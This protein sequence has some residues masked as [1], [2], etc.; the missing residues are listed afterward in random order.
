MNPINLNGGSEIEARRTPARAEA[1]R[2][3]APN[4]LPVTGNTGSLPTA[5]TISVSDGLARVGELT[6]Q[7]GQL[8]DVR[9]EYVA[10]LREQVQSGNYHPS[11]E[12]IAAAL[13]VSRV[14][15]ALKL[16]GEPPKA[17][18][19]FPIDLGTQLAAAATASLTPDSGS[20]RWI[21]VLEAIAF[22]PIRGQVKPTAAPAQPS[23][24]LIATVT[25][26]APLL[27]Q[28]ATLFNVKVAPGGHTPRPLRPARPAKATRPKP[29][30]DQPPSPTPTPDVASTSVEGA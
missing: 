28:I 18:Q 7:A 3:A 24:A 23:P 9:L 15:R 29:K 21:A 2:G 6:A 1:E 22:S 27:P 20:D 5:D 14:V 19:P 30:M 25:R 10:Q 13:G 17:G 16:S 26:L 4:T 12:D 11:A 8:P